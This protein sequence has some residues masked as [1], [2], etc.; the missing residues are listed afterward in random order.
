MRRRVVNE[1]KK[2]IPL[3]RLAQESSYSAAYVSILV[4]RKKLRAKKIGRNYFSTREWF[5]EYLETHAREE[6]RQ[7]IKGAPRQPSI[8]V[9][10]TTTAATLH[11]VVSREEGSA[12]DHKPAVSK[13]SKFVD[14][15]VSRLEKVLSG[16]IVEQKKAADKVEPSIAGFKK[17]SHGASYKLTQEWQDDFI[18]A[19]RSLNHNL[20]NKLNSQKLEKRLAA[21]KAYKEKLNRFFSANKDKVLAWLRQRQIKVVVTSKKL[22]RLIEAGLLRL[23]EVSFFV[24]LARLFSS[25]FTILWLGL[26]NRT[27]QKLTSA[28]DAPSKIKTPLPWRTKLARVMVV[29]LVVAVSLGWFAPGVSAAL[30]KI[31]D[32]VY[33]EPIIKASQLAKQAIP[34]VKQQVQQLAYQADK[35]RQAIK[36]KLN[37]VFSQVKQKQDKVAIA[38]QH[39]RDSAYNLATPAVKPIVSYFKLAKEETVRLGSGQIN[40]IN[41]FAQD[42]IIPGRKLAEKSKQGLVNLIIDLTNKATI[43]GIKFENNIKRRNKRLAEKLNFVRDQ[44]VFVAG[45]WQG[46]Y[47]DKIGPVVYGNYNAVRLA[48]YQGID[49]TKDKFANLSLSMK[50]VPRQLKRFGQDGLAVLRGFVDYKSETVRE[51]AKITGKKLKSLGSDFSDEVA[52]TR[53]VSKKGDEQKRVQP[54]IG[55]LTGRVAGASERAVIIESSPAVTKLLALANTTAQRSKQVITTVKSNAKNILQTGADKQRELSLNLGRALTKLV[56]TSA[57]QI[58]KISQVGGEKL[59]QVVIKIN[60]TNK[61]IKDQGQLG[62]RYLACEAGRSIWS[63]SDIYVKTVDF[64][65][66]DSLKGYYAQMYQTDSR[67]QITDSRRQTTNNRGAEADANIIAQEIIQRVSTPSTREVR[68]LP[69][70]LILE[71]IIGPTALIGDLD[72]TG[73]NKVNGNLNIGDKFTVEGQSELVGDVFV[74]GPTRFDQQITVIGGAD[75]MG[76]IYNS[77]GSVVV[78]DN[79]DVKMALAAKTL[80]VTDWAEIGGTLNA[81]DILANDVRIRKNLT[82]VGDSV[83]QGSQAVNGDLAVSGTF[84]AGHTQFASLGVTGS[85]GANNLSAGAGGLSVSGDTYLSGDNVYIAGAIDLNNLLDIDKNSTQA[86]TVG[87]GTTNTFVVNTKDDTITINGDMTFSGDLDLNNALDID[88]ASTSALAVGDGSVDN[89][90]VD[91]VNDQITIGY[92]STTDRVTVNSRQL[93]INSASSTTAIVVNYDGTGNILQVVDNAITRFTIADWGNIAQTASSTSYAYILNQAGT[94][95]NLL[96]IQDQGTDR[97]LIA[98]WGVITQTASTSTGYAYTLNQA[99]ESGSL[100]DIQDQ[101]VSRFSIAD[102]G[103]ITQTAS[104]TNYALT[105]NQ[106]GTSGSLLKIQDQG[107]DRFV[108]A[109]WGVTTL[110][111][112]STGTA[113][114]VRQDSTGDILNLYD[115]ATEMLTVLDGGNIGIGTTSPDSLLT[116]YSDGSKTGPLFHVATSSTDALYHRR[117]APQRYCWHD[118]F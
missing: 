29:A 67:Q 3:R 7:Q 2:L 86:L 48:L 60:Q 83:I 19:N 96:A 63:L 38:W 69:N 47:Q 113:L 115:G 102:W 76:G 78:D 34:V 95:G 52:R 88:V 64:L 6:K 93:T 53:K 109:D 74:G 97:F 27:K 99:G 31:M 21:R 110:T 112:S 5:N 77:Q 9:G 26:F 33:L 61:S 117:T 84:S 50:L 51:M 94:A 56:I 44:M 87:D 82:V 37:N 59:D 66:P 25:S 20:K 16:N 103:V 18:K 45:F 4:Q 42:K 55:H 43:A 11:R 72:I 24:D 54:N 79:L 12:A 98:D 40:Q 116:V 71:E 23:Y 35:E 8:L 1:N 14:K 41:K 85:L 90:T 46:V 73:N 111:A 10:K 92:S 81:S 108:I 30:G 107:T 100:L 62:K 80:K 114:T 58:S 32:K 17:L 106:A 65:I 118:T 91:T 36:A 15:S 49:L 105:I 70:K 39:G 75:L 101:G 22:T 68:T 28:K 13:H 89:L 57:E 104:S